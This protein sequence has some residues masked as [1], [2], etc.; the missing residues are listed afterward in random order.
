[1]YGQTERHCT[2]GLNVPTA[3]NLGD[4]ISSRVLI[5]AALGESLGLSP[6][7]AHISGCPYKG[8]GQL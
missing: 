8:V 3:S 4:N 5:R 6:T 2:S 7:V 1:M